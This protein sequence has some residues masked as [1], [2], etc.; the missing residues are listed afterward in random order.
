MSLP[1]TRLRICLCG[2]SHAR[3]KA[4]LE[5]ALPNDE[6]IECSEAEL[7]DIARDCE[8]LIPVVTR[9]PNELFPGSRIRLIQQYGV[10]LDVVDIPAATRAGIFVAN[11]SSVGTGNAESVAELAIAHLLMLLRDI[12]LAMQRFRE[13]K[14]GSPLG[15]SLW[16]STV[17]VLGYGDIGQEIARRLIAFDVRVI[18]VSRHGPSGVRPRD[19]NVRPAVH[20]GIQELHEVIAAAD[21]VIVAAP[22]SPENIGLVDARMLSAMKPGSV[23]VNIARGAVVDYTALRAALEN[24]HLAGAGLDVFWQE[25]FDPEDPLLACRVIATPHIGG[26][27]GRSLAGIGTAVVA[28]IERLRS[29]QKLECCANPQAAQESLS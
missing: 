10:G 12:P 1:R 20:V 25:P 19:P 8:V 14:L 24:G 15:R 28:N 4:L 21:A 23:L 27:T 26:V 9:I 3:I 6:I 22:A 29:G 13:R 7:A 18:A 2:R 17:L 11:V 16:G 5:T